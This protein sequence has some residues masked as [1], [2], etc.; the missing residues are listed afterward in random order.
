[1]LVLATGAGGAWTAFQH[2]FY[3]AFSPQ[4]PIA[5]DPA[6]IT[7]FSSLGRLCIANMASR[8]GEGDYDDS[9]RAF[10][11]AFMARSTMT[12]AEARPVLAAI[13]SVHGI[14]LSGS[15]HFTGRY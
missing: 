7:I 10:L 8:S 1:M 12:F 3:T 14:L 2:L 6:A 15:S 11:Q 9:N 4:K 5:T 13:F